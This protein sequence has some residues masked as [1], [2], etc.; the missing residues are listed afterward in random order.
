MIHTLYSGAYAP[1]QGAQFLLDLM[2]RDFSQHKPSSQVPS[3]IYSAFCQATH[4]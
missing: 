4:V 3:A 2:Q 1:H